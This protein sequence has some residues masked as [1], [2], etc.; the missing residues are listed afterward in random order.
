[1]FF[2]PP[3]PGSDSRDTGPGVMPYTFA[4]I[5]QGLN[6]IAPY[7]WANFWQTRLNALDFKALT[8]GLEA[9]GYDYVYQEKMIPEE[10]EF[11]TASHAVEMYHSL[12]FQAAPDGTLQDVWIGSPAFVAGL[13]PGDKLTAV[14]G[15]PY[16]AELL[17][18]AVHDSKTNPKPIVLTAVRDDEA[19]VYEINYHGG[20]KYAAL[21]RNS[22]PD[23]LTTAILQPR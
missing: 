7:D 20:E 3:V 22:N 5:V 2:A 18:A 19:R 6:T 1:L 15:K 21:I 16:T 4:D 13:G 12:G 17:T 8:G 11:I 23:V 9:A 10:A 14:N